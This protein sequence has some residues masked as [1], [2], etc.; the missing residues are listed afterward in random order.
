MTFSGIAGEAVLQGWQKTEGKRYVPIIDCLT[1]IS[2]PRSK[3]HE[4]SYKTAQ[5]LC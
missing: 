3:A 5:Y 4:N 1:D 2:A